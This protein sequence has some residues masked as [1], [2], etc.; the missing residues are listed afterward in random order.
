[1]LD[2]S[3]RLPVRSK[4]VRSAQGDLLVF[5]ASAAS[6]RVWELEEAGVRL[7]R[8]DAVN[9]HVSLARVVER[10]GEMKMLSVLL[11]GGSRLNS[12]A[13]AD[14]IVDKLCLFYAPVFL[15]SAGVPLLAASE[16]IQLAPSRIRWVSVAGDA[17]FE[18]Y[19][20]DPWI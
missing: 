16:R 9:G 10:L 18:A 15:G 4:L 5:H 6:D 13:L 8:I 19:L 1:V 12:A 17:C 11:E 14:G 7:E 20:R 3:L 2:S